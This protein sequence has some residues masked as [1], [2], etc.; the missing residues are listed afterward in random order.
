MCISSFWSNGS[1]VLDFNR[2]HEAWGDVTVFIILGG[3]S[4]AGLVKFLKCR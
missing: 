1:I 3:M 4:L 2:Y